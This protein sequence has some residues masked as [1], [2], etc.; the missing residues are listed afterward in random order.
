MDDLI[1]F[2]KGLDRCWMERRFADLSGYIA[3]DVIMVAPGG[4]HRMQ[5]IEAA[6]ASYRDFMSRCDVKRFQTS[7]HV[8]TRRGPAAV[9]E[10][11]WDMCWSDQ[12]IEHEDKGREVLVLT[13][14]ADEWRVVWRT[15]IPA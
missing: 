1:A 15:Q 10:Y 2:A 8:V 5:G 12:G 14:H 6:V 11:D 9:I 13:R 3:S 7:G 4:K